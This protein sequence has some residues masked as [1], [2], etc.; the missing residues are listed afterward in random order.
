M[1]DSTKALAFIGSP[2]V[3]G[4]TGTSIDAVKVY[5]YRPTSP[6][7]SSTPK[8]L[9][10][11]IKVCEDHKTGLQR[12]KC[13]ITVCHNMR[14]LA[15]CAIYPEEVTSQAPGLTTSEATDRNACSSAQKDLHRLE[16]DSS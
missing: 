14:T 16:A 9:V 2:A 11:G 3:S 5:Y 4:T 7:P 1:Y 10:M 6:R 8:P 12:G 15:T 13:G